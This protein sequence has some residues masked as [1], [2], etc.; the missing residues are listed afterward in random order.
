MYENFIK[1]MLTCKF[2][3]DLEISENLISGNFRIRYLWSSWSGQ[4][5]TLVSYSSQQNAITLSPNISVCFMD[6]IHFCVP[7][8]H[9]GRS[10][11]AIFFRLTSDGAEKLSC[12]YKNNKKKKNQLISLG[13]VSFKFWKMR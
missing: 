10:K 3:T 6:L 13:L 7:Y 1:I 11:K 4:Q 2:E 5:M 12:N 8:M 9:W